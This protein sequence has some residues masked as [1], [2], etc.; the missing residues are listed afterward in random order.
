MK[1]PFLLILIFA[2]LFLNSCISSLNSTPEQ[3]L[4][5]RVNAL[6]QARGI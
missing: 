4:E 3:R 5:K 6:M 1:K 2:F